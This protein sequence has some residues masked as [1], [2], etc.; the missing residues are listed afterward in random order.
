MKD[1]REITETPPY[2]PE[3][4]FNSFDWNAPIERRIDY[5]L[6]R[7]HKSVEIRGYNRFKRTSLAF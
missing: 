1:S 4:N 5:I 2:G 3:G 6:H 7:Q